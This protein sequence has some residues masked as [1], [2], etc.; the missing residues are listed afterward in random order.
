MT[1]PTE[2][3]ETVDHSPSAEWMLDQFAAPPAN[4]S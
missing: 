4:S 1:T 3:S 2:A